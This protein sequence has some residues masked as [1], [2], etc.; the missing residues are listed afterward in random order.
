MS[1][2]TAD[3]EARLTGLEVKLSF[4]EDLIESLNDTVFRQQRQIEALATVL[5]QLREQAAE[6]GQPG[7]ANLRD[8]IPPHY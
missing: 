3:L 8:D 1:E 5:A 4:A 7:T 6:P 2:S